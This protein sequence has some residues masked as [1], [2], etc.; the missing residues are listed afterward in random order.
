M[1][2]RTDLW[3]PGASNRLGPPGRWLFPASKSSRRLHSAI[4]RVKQEGLEGISI[5]QTL[6]VSRAAYC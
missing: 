5:C 1:R 3:E 2:A 4:D 6:G